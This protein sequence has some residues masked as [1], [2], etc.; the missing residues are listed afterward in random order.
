M[1]NISLGVVMDPISAIKIAKDSTFAMLLEAQE[2]GWK[3]FYIEQSDLYVKDGAAWSFSRELRVADDARKWYSLESGTERKLSGIDVILMR[4][5]PPFDM[6]YIYSTY[7]LELAAKQGTLVVND[8]AALRDVNEKLSTAWF[9][10]CCPPTLVSRNKNRLK[11]FL[12]SLG[13]IV[14][15]PLDAMGGESVFRIRDDDPNANVILETITRHETRMTIAQRF[16][17]EYKQGDKRILVIDGKPFPYALARIP[18]EGEARANL[19]V[20]GLGKGVELSERD[21]WICREIG[22]ILRNRGILFAGLDVIGEYLTEINVTSPTCIRELQTIY[23]TNIS[24]QIMDSIMSRLE[25]RP[26]TSIY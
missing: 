14:V 2:R 23:N 17:P 7:I 5:D 3:L 1:M 24:A 21:R 8:P 26:N 6:E 12:Q 15:K 16:I 9:P 13:E 25:K 11:S 4:K 20:G 10:N 18:A 19:A 22:P